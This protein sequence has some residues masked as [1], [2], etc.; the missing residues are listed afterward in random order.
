MNSKFG[1]MALTFSALSMAAG[2]GSAHAQGVLWGG[3]LGQYQS[4]VGGVTNPAFQRRDARI[5]FAWNTVGP[6]GSLSPEFNTNGWQNFSASWTGQV[7][8]TTSETYTLQVVAN[9]GVALYF[10]P[11]GSTTW[12]TLYADYGNSAKTAQ[13][14]VALTAGTSYDICVHYWEQQPNGRLQLGWSSPSVPFQVI[15]A[16]TP[17]GINGSVALPGEPGNMFADI[18]KQAGGFTV[19]SNAQMPAPLDAQGWPLADATLPLWS[20]GRELDGVYQMSFTGQAQVTDWSGVGSFSVNGV[21]YGTI[22]PVGAGYDPVANKTTATWTVAAATAPTAA[23]LGFGQSQRSPAAPVGSGITNLQILRPVA[24][25]STGVHGAGELFSAQY[26]SFLSYFSGIRFMDYLATNGNRQQHW[27][28]RVTP[29]QAS[30]Y[31]A[32]G[33]YGWQGKGGSLEYLVALAN[34]TGKDA[35][36]NIPV[37][38]DD[39]YVTKLAQLL[40]FGSD[41]TTPYTSAQAHPAYPPLNSNL[42]VYLEYSNELWNTGYVQSSMNQSLA[43]AAVAAGGS[44]L[45]YDGATDPTVWAK[46]RVVDRT[47]RISSLFR[48]VWGDALM[49]ARVRPV[50]EWQYGNSGNTAAIGL[51]YLENFYDNADGVAHVASPHPANYYL[52]GGGGGWYQSANSANAGS[53]AAIY[54]SGETSPSTEGDAIWALGFGLHEMGYEGGFEVGGDYPSA[55]QLSANLDPNA[56]AFE[57]TA[58]NKFFQ[59]GGGMPFVFNAAGATAYGIA[60]PTIADQAT[61]KMQAILA[62]IQNTR[63]ASA[64]AWPLPIDAGNIPVSF[65]MGVT[66]SGTATGTLAHVGDYIAWSV[67]VQTASGFTITTDAPNPATTQIRIDGVPVAAGTWAGILPIGLHG[68]MVRNLSSAGTTLTKLVVTPTATNNSVK[69]AK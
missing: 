5:D 60:N 12:T 16:A 35:W 52:W 43:S 6:G 24:P 65:S 38:V 57:T 14:A 21:G 27:A 63:P 59:M 3:F 17:V 42:K 9:G 33:G 47:V 41:G 2:L 66:P 7:M 56:Q 64:F 31:Q 23:T 68:I 44:P 49:M 13:K 51:G 46:R 34:E 50:F 45:A 67:N 36:I 58:I 62:A 1:A 39:D 48:S 53:V 22:L 11:T 20:T 29:G 19:Y 28:D 40:A 25:G 32:V 55:V 37:G 30:Q 18:M 4:G 8:A 69:P 10:R 61:P 15:E 26:K 54:A